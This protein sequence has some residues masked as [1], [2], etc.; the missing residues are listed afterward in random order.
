MGEAIVRVDNVASISRR[1]WMAR[2]QTDF[3]RFTDMLLQTSATQEAGS[4]AALGLRRR[5]GDPLACSTVGGRSRGSGDSYTE[6]PRASEI[7]KAVATTSLATRATWRLVR[8]NVSDDTLTPADRPCRAL[9]F[10]AM[11]R[12]LPSFSCSSTA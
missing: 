7:P 2:D 1:E 12:M 6:W 9:T 8:S 3:E 11:Q 10:A 4:T 5:L